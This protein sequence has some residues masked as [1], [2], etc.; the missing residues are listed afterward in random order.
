MNYNNFKYRILENDIVLH[1][2]LGCDN[3]EF[4]RGD[5]NAL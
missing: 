3:A 2:Y 1:A 4:F 5:E